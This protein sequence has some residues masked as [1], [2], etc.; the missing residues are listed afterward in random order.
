MMSI[1]MFIAHEMYILV[2]A[3]LFL[4]GTKSRAKRTNGRKANDFHSAQYQKS[5]SARK[6]NVLLICNERLV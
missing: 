6:K 5:P 3:S 2:T 4:Y 1:C